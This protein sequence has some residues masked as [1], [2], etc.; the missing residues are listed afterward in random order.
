[1]PRRWLALAAVTLALLLPAA[2]VAQALSACAAHHA[3]AAPEEGLP[4]G[5]PSRRPVSGHQPSNRPSPPV[6]ESTPRMKCGC[7]DAD[8]VRVPVAPPTRGV[9]ARRAHRR[10]RRLCGLRP[11]SRSSPAVSPDYASPQS[12]TPARHSERALTP[13]AAAPTGVHVHASGAVLAG[14]ARSILTGGN[15]FSRV[16]IAGALVAS[17]VA[18]VPAARR[19]PGNAQPCERQRPRHRHDGAGIAA[20]QVTARHRETNVTGSATTDVDGRFRFAYL[21]V[22]PYEITVKLNGFATVTRQISLSVGAAF[23]LPITMP[24]A[25]VETSVTVNAECRDARDGSEPDRGHRLRSRGQDA[26][27][28]RPQLSRPRAA[29]ARRV[30]DQRR[31]RHAA[32]SGDVGSARRQHLGRQPAQSLEQLHRRRTLGE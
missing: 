12:L 13:R 17:G 1:M 24:V 2:P 3:T 4:P 25:T 11:S 9:R 20:A 32:V 5:Q 30:A 31:R 22:G 16:L 10:L 18:G 28:E 19:G 29:R 14:D 7:S 23:D 6:P 26:A 15:M 21:R 27:P 8:R